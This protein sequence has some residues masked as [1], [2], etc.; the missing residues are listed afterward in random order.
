MFLTHKMLMKLENI[1]LT[2]IVLDYKKKFDST[3]STITNDELR[4][5][6]TNFHNLKLTWVAVATSTKNLLSSLR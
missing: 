6:N 3:L 5:L 2:G 1:V 4:E